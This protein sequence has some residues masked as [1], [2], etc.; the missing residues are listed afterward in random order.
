MVVEIKFVKVLLIYTEKYSLYINYLFVILGEN[1]SSWNRKDLVVR[2]NRNIV[3]KN[4]DQ[5]S[6]LVFLDLSI[7][8]LLEI[9]I[10][11][12]YE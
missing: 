7:N 2:K 8:K 11:Y 6:L 10:F 5:K 1:L 12:L 9:F 3:Q 4:K